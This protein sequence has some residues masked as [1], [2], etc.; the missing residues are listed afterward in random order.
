V[1]GFMPLHLSSV[2]QLNTLFIPRVKQA[3]AHLFDA[4]RA[5]SQFKERYPL[6]LSSYVVA[7]PRVQEALALQDVYAC[8][9]I[10]LSLQSEYH[11]TLSELE[12]ARNN[13]LESAVRKKLLLR[14]FELNY[15]SE[16][17]SYIQVLPS[18]ITHLNPHSFPGLV[19]VLNTGP[20]LEKII[21]AVQTI[22]G[23]LESS[24]RHIKSATQPLS[25]VGHFPTDL[26][27]PDIYLIHRDLVHD[28]VE[29]CVSVQRH[30]DS[31][32]VVP[33]EAPSFQSITYLCS[34]LEFLADWLMAFIPVHLGLALDE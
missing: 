3:E 4:L 29:F 7:S 9:I 12:S 22:K 20:T 1:F 28:L 31:R 33:A 11:R 18:L 6:G 34:N 10:G 30:I 16:V 2:E 25:L 17:H 5:L 26:L 24:V 13:A 21:L 14:L 19:E 15:W 8:Y 32:G 23:R 27:H